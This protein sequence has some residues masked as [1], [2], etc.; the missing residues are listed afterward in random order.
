MRHH[1]TLI[2]DLLKS[3]PWGTFDR[4]VEKHG[5]DTHVRTL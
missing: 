4:L 3:M 5:S 2:D 1:N